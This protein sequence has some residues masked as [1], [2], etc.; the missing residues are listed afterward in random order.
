MF[1]GSINR[2][3][4]RR[5][6]FAGLAL[7][8]VFALSGCA[9]VAFFLA[10]LEK[11]TAL[12]AQC[13][14][15]QSA[16]EKWNWTCDARAEEKYRAFTLKS[17]REERCAVDTASGKLCNKKD[18]KDFNEAQTYVWE[19]PPTATP[20]P[21]GMDVRSVI[22]GKGAGLNC[23][24]PSLAEKWFIKPL[25]QKSQG[26]ATTAISPASLQY[27][28]A[29]SKHDFCYRHG[30]ATYGYKQPDCDDLL[31]DQAFR[32]C[33]KIYQS[34]QPA[35]PNS[36]IKD[37]TSGIATC[38]QQA[39]LVRLGVRLFGDTAYQGAGKS[40]Y[41]EFDPM[42]RGT[43]MPFSVARLIEE[44]ATKNELLKTY[45]LGDREYVAATGRDPKTKIVLGGDSR[46]TFAPPTLTVNATAEKQSYQL[47]I[48]TRAELKNTGYTF[49]GLDV[50]DKAS[51][52][53]ADLDCDAAN[54][55]ITSFDNTGR[56]VVSGPDVSTTFTLACPGSLNLGGR[57]QIPVSL[58]R[59][60]SILKNNWYRLYDQPRVNGNFTPDSNEF[61]FVARGY[62]DSDNTASHAGID[63]KRLVTL[64]SLKAGENANDR[65]LRKAEIGEDEAPISAY[66][67]VSKST[68]ILIGI[69][70]PSKAKRF[71]ISRWELKNDKWEA[72]H[73]EAVTGLDADISWLQM[74]VQ[75]VRTPAG[76][77]ELVFTRVCLQP[78]PYCAMSFGQQWVD[79]AN[80]LF[81]PKVVYLSSQSWRLVDG[82]WE[83]SSQLT[84]EKIDL[85]AMTTALI[86]KDSDSAAKDVFVNVRFAETS[87][88]D[89]SYRKATHAC[90]DANATQPECARARQIAALLWHQSQAIAAARQDS[91][92]I[93][94]VP[95]P[96][97][98]FY[99]MIV[100][101]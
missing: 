31:F 11:N 3:G 62:D 37:G 7:S 98:R 30:F 9:N 17:L 92:G 47:W 8:L 90:K 13:T 95:H 42:A 39:A 2:V 85:M 16:S 36:G 49:R 96:F 101:K 64:A 97:N 94:F 52:K 43:R 59:G 83:Q 51:R 63:Y 57:D 91:L 58:I 55:S 88:P 65:V 41:F 53:G 54:V 18:N 82:K 79:V 69:V 50:K 60:K 33:A 29:C 71:C 46:K 27:A 67:P 21:A 34:P 93:Y 40:T 80:G 28:Q 26:T 70:A 77:D 73:C 6:T 1:N 5:F 76:H 89:D 23:S 74:P 22:G 12:E 35:D 66:R 4:L 10:E 68:D 99:Q 84:E 44:P 45:F 100:L 78:K 25:Q 48:T 81:D 24:I 38:Q 20:V 72:A 75:V 86:A 87:D 19:Q 56:V 14:P 32:I 61:V 15:K